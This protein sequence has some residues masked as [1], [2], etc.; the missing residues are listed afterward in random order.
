MDDSP[1]QRDALVSSC[2]RLARESRTFGENG[3][4]MLYYLRGGIDTLSVVQAHLAAFIVS[5]ES[6]RSEKK[7]KFIYFPLLPDESLA[8]EGVLMW[9]RSTWQYMTFDEGVQ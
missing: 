4:C 8:V 7:V 9:I 1:C 3:A 2:A 6:S 5:T